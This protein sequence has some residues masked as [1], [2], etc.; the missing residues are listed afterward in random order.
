MAVKI[1]KPINREYLI[2][3]LEKLSGK[4]LYELLKNQKVI[5]A[6]E[7]YVVDD[8]TDPNALL[9]IDDSSNTPA[10]GEIGLSE[11]EQYI[12]D[13]SVSAGDY[14]VHQDE[15]SHLE[16]LVAT[17]YA[18][19]EGTAMDTGEWEEIWDVDPE[20]VEVYKSLIQDSQ[21]SS[22]LLWSSQKVFDSI[23][24]TKVI[25]KEYVDKLLGKSATLKFE[26]VTS[27]PTTGNTG[28]LYLYDNGTSF[29]VYIYSETL[30][31]INTGA[32]LQNIDLSDYLR[33][34]VVVQNTTTVSS[35]TVLSSI[36]TKQYVDT[37]VGKSVKK[38][39]LL[40][41]TTTTGTDTVFSSKTIKDYV[42]GKTI[43]SATEPTSAEDG[44]MWIETY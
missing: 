17:K 41:D 19:R 20:D 44:S 15:Q 25:A 1:D 18:L 2:K 40:Q 33:N 10:T 9:I 24:Q 28:T 11:V 30:G 36:G 32:D 22:S 5:D 35:T 31:W 38:A 12:T 37:E 27:L 16:D 34:D 3:Q 4:E 13:G 21:I 26:V 7:S 6:A 43:M 29:P 8:G 39:D 14:V 42:D 23:E